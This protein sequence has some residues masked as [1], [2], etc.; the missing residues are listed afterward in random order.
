MLLTDPLTGLV[1]NV[2]PLFGFKA[3]G[4]DP[5]LPLYHQAMLRPD[6]EEFRQAQSIEIEALEKKRTWDLTL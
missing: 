4:T 3:K 5:D 2:N 6:A 1:D